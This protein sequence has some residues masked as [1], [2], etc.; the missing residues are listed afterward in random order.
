MT[1]LMLWK[2]VFPLVQ[3]T[4]HIESHADFLA[5]DRGANELRTK[6]A[7]IVFP[8]QGFLLC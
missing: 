3:K 6:S 1:F 5:D 4:K 8:T 2:R 7:V